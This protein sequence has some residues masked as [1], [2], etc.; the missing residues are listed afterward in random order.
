LIQGCFFLPG[1]AAADDVVR[2]PALCASELGREDGGGVKGVGRR[3]GSGLSRRVRPALCDVEPFEC[4]TFFAL[5]Q[6]CA[7]KCCMLGH[8]LQTKHSLAF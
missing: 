2:S 7:F 5:F 6:S 3:P 8:I 4:S 1:V